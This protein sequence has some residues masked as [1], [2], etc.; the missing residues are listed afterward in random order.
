MLVQTLNK[1]TIRVNVSKRFSLRSIVLKGLKVS[2]ARTQIGYIRVDT[3]AL[4]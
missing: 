3:S 2:E 1:T 4:K